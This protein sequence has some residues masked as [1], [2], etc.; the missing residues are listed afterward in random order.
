M[1]WLLHGVGGLMKVRMVIL[2]GM[3]DDG[4]SR[5]EGGSYVQDLQ[6]GMDNASQTYGQ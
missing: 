2:L 5:W 4:K 6:G 1:L 3:L